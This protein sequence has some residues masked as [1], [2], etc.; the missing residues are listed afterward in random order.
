M[1]LTERQEAEQEVAEV[2]MLRFFMGVTRRDRI[3][4]ERTRAMTHVGDILETKLE[5]PE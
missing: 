4:K 1:E 2:M 3:R 5:T